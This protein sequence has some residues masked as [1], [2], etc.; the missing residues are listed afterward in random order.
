MKADV[1]PFSRVVARPLGFVS[2]GMALFMAL[3]T[4]TMPLTIALGG[5]A[6]PV[7]EN[8]T[9]P[10]AISASICGLFGLGLW[11]HGR[12]TAGTKFGRREGTFVVAV[13]WLGTGLFGGLPYLLGASMSPADAFFESV[14]GFTTTGATVVAEIEDAKMG[15]SKPVLLWRA[16]TQWLGGM[17]IVV[18]FVAV[19]PNFGVGGKHL[20][21]S[22]A[23]GPPGASIRPRIA[24]TSLFLW[25]L[26]AL[27]TVVLLGLLWVQGM[28][29][30]E[31]VCH[32]LTGL[33]TGGFSTRNG[34]IGSFDSLGI[35]L[36]IAVFILISGVNFS[37]YYGALKFRS[38]QV[39]FK[40]TEFRVYLGI[41]VACVTL[42]TLFLFPSTHANFFEALRR[43][44]FTVA[45]TI[46]S[47]GFST[48]NYTVYP[49]VALGMFL[50]LMFIGGS[51]GSTSGGIKVARVTLL[52]KMVWAQSRKSF[53]P[54]VIHVVRMGK[55]PVSDSVLSEVG[56]FFIV[57]M[58]ILGAGI[59]T[60]A[61]IEG[62]SLPASFGAVLTCVSNMGPAPFHETQ[63]DNFSEYSHTAKYLL[64]LIMI[65]GRLEFFTL[66]SLLLPDFWKR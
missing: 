63:A 32:A 4:L 23:P 42:M 53:R 29:F 64:S 25:K 47:T 8:A 35:E 21:R 14:S 38:I 43:S 45:T 52:F 51:A 49:P 28:N 61:M 41:T 5:Q 7:D 20:F 58:L 17:G 40:S 62:F 57:Y 13:I 34:S 33:A 22:E 19:F 44:F 50:A 27:M 65:L 3:C 48:D 2:A 31:S 66:L 18:L 1:A 12:A 15:L 55:K 24:E 10:M 37:L 16:L 9:L 6:R 36:T 26:Y 46:T 60:I 54:S 11:W 39:F 56:A 30:F 59:L